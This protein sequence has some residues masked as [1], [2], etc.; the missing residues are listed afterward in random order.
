MNSSYSLAEYKAYESVGQ[1]V[2]AKITWLG[3][4]RMARG[5]N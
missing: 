4:T 5:V 3:F 2:G 1:G